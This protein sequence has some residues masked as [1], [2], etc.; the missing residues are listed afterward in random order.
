MCSLPRWFSGHTQ[1]RSSLAWNKPCVPLSAT[2]L[3]IGRN[4]CLPKKSSLSMWHWFFNLAPRPKPDVYI[5]VPTFHLTRHSRNALTRSSVGVLIMLEYV[6]PSTLLLETSIV[7]PSSLGEMGTRL[8]SSHRVGVGSM[9]QAFVG[10]G[11]A[12]ADLKDKTWK[13]YKDV[14]VGTMLEFY[15]GSFVMWN[16]QFAQC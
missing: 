1:H 14:S 15:I 11:N 16:C 2:I 3:G 6:W 13:P 5:R 12:S 8:S 7:M 4:P 10:E 9:P